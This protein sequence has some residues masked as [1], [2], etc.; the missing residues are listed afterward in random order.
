MSHK[1]LFTQLPL[2]IQKE[3][4]ERF[5]G[6]CALYGYESFFKLQE[7]HVLV[8][9]NGGVGSWIAESLC[10]T[11]IGSISLL[12]FDNIELSNSN[13]QL[14]TLSSTLNCSKAQ[15][16]GKRLLDINPY[17]RLQ[18]LPVL[19][20]KDNFISS[21]AQA[22]NIKETT[23]LEK[24]NTPL[25]SLSEPDKLIKQKSQQ[26]LATSFCSFAFNG[27][28]TKQQTKLQDQEELLVSGNQVD[29]IAP[30]IYVAEAIDD[31]FVKAS[32]VDILHRCQIPI[33]TSGGAGGRI[34]PSYLQMGDVAKAQGDQLMKRLRTELRRNYGYPK[35]EGKNSSNFKIMCSFSTETPRMT[36]SHTKVEDLLEF[37]EDLEQLNPPAL[38]N[39]GASV[40]VTASAGLQISSMI[41]RWIIS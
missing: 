37:Y 2:N 15:T 28:S 32:V 27:Y 18:T 35:G 14:H 33:I 1:Y 36:K 17:L 10:R 25:N 4:L 19:L 13:R 39:F 41:I 9:G 26:R 24:K 40:S 31:L 22:L 20:Q 5:K 38:P 6:V 21:L 8:I 11:G 34:D 7:S 29:K 3:Q 30:N 16:L 12:D 23:L